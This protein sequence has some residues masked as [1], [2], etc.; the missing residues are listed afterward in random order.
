MFLMFYTIFTGLII[1][2]SILWPVTFHLSLLGNPITPCYYVVSWF[3]GDTYRLEEHLFIRY[4]DQR[5]F[6]L[7]ATSGRVKEWHVSAKLSNAVGGR[8]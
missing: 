6:V 4:Y 2:K 5:R 3:Y 7:G 8:V 1:Y